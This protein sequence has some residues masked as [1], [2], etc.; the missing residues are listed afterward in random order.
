[1]PLSSHLEFIKIPLYTESLKMTQKIINQMSDNR[2]PWDGYKASRSEG[3][4]I[5]KHVLLEQN[6]GSTIIASHLLIFVIV[7][8]DCRQRPLLP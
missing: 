8:F 1:M 3:E 6:E 4:H 7:G 2:P 5:E